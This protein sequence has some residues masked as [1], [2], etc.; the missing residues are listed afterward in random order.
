MV[1]EVCGKN[2]ATIHFTQIINSE[3][4]EMQLCQECAAKQGFQSSSGTVESIVSKIVSGAGLEQTETCDT[5][6]C[7]ACGTSYKQFQESGRLGCGNCYRVF[8]EKLKD[9]LRKIHGSV[10]HVGK[11]PP[12]QAG[13][14][15][16]HHRLEELREK[17]RKAIRAEQFEEAA[18]LRDEIKRLEGGTR[19]N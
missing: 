15:E 7:S 11:V 13:T 16:T 12:H 2:E 14:Y 5:L 6:V 8:E 10:Q 3:K 18:L 9:L 1:C 17:M 19:G 4:K